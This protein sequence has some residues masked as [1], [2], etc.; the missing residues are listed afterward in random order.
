MLGKIP[1]TH[2]SKRSVKDLTNL[3]G[4]PADHFKTPVLDGK[5]VKIGFLNRRCPGASSSSS[6]LSIYSKS[7]LEMF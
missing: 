2:R 1:D 4:G 5:I 6:K 7:V 3:I